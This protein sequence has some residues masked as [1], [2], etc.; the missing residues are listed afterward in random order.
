MRR[1]T[2]HRRSG[3]RGP[4]RKSYWTGFIYQG[5]EVDLER[6]NTVA[7][8]WA[9]LPG[10]V[11][12]ADTGQV[13]LETNQTL[14]RTIISGTVVLAPIGVV[15]GVNPT[16]VV[17]GLIAWDTMNPGEL[18]KVIVTSDAAPNPAEASGLDWILRVPF[19]FTED[20]FELSIEA[21][22]FINSRAMRKLPPGTGILACI[23]GLNV[24]DPDP[25]PMTLSWS[26][27][28]RMMM[29]AGQITPGALFSI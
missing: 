16:D 11:R 21:D 15:Q 8:A 17:F 5:Q 27:D 12:N 2:S 29:K 3:H 28:V 20:N 9:V 13:V 14:V 1:R 10:G 23:A 19:T 4:V 7:T 26:L 24:I 25:D 18:D 6:R 22:T